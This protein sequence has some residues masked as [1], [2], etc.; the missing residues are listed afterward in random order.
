MPNAGLRMRPSPP[1]R[2]NTSPD[3]RRIPLLRRA[4]REVGNQNRR[5]VRSK[6]KTHCIHGH[7]YTEDNSYFPPNGRRG[8]RECRRIAAKAR[9]WRTPKAHRDRSTSYR[10][11][12]PEVCALR[13]R[14][15][16]KDNPEVCRNY[17][18]S[19]RALKLNQLGLW[20][21]LIPQL[22]PA[23]LQMQNECCAYCR[24][25]FGEEGYELE[26]MTPI[27]RGGSHGFDNVVLAC[28][29]CNLRKHT[30]S[31]EEFKR[32]KCP[33]IQSNGSSQPIR[34]AGLSNALGVPRE[35]VFGIGL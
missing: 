21:G 35:E 14:Q 9:Y 2:I 34:N 1:R 11:K 31:A 26:H 12:N 25:P 30:K 4:V 33:E 32:S 5:A 20:W 19:R 3:R 18:R 15:W 6:V 23:M 28:P 24:K 27:A 13:K 8:C 29:P 22:I 17:T 7:E 10:L 16:N